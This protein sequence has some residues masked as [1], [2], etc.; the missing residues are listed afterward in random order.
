[1]RNYKLRTPEDVK[2]PIKVKLEDSE[3]LVLNSIF[4]GYDKNGDVVITYAPERAKPTPATLIAQKLSLP[5]KA[6]SYA[7]NLVKAEYLER[8][9]EKRKVFAE[10]LEK[11]IEK[12]ER[13]GEEKAS[14]V[15]KELVE[16]IKDFNKDKV[17]NLLVAISHLR[18]EELKE[19]L[20]ENGNLKAE[21]V[22]T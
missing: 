21:S 19:L 20:K 1:V 10:K 7:L 17:I 12:L 18:R 9:P 6:Y 22:K 2:E 15:L 13:A 14:E 8:K 5:Y 3:R 4:V 16:S 11:Y